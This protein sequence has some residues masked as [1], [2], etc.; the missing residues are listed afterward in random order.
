MNPISRTLV[1]EKKRGQLCFYALLLGISS[2]CSSFSIFSPLLD[3][4]LTAGWHIL[5]FFAI[6]MALIP[7]L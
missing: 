1:L 2:T 7:S 5:S 3:E 6:A 4:G